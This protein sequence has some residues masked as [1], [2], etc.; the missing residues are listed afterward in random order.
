MNDWR[1]DREP[2]IET[3]APEDLALSDETAEQVKGGVGGV[4]K[5][6]MEAGQAQLSALKAG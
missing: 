1:E 2:A 3:E 4:M 5:T 6:E